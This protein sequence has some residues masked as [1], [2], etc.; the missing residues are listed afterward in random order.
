MSISWSSSR[1]SI[2]LHWLLGEYGR[3]ACTWGHVNVLFWHNM[4]SVEGDA[5]QKL[6]QKA[7]MTYHLEVHSETLAKA[8][9]YN[10][11]LQIKVKHC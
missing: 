1:L 9:E 11:F 3:E 6:K 10:I 7:L 8:Q 2:T 5:L 4:L